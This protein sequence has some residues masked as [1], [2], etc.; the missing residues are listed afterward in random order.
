MINPKFLVSMSIIHGWLMIKPSVC[1][2]K[3]HH[4]MMFTSWLLMVELNRYC[5][6]LDML[7]HHHFDDLN[8][9]WMVSRQA[10]ARC[11]GRQA[12]RDRWVRQAGRFPSMCDASQNGFCIL[13]QRCCFFFAHFQSHWE[14]LPSANQTWQWKL[15]HLQYPLVN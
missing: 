15:F 7:K 5:W 12:C 9:W 2:M 3:N 11:S 8:Q 1:L 4:F 10:P 14:K 6:C 13:A